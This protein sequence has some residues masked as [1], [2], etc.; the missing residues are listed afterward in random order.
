MVVEV[1]ALMRGIRAFLLLL[2]AQASDAETYT[3]IKTWAWSGVV[4]SLWAGLVEVLWA[5]G[6]VALFD[7]AEDFALDEMC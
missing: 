5:G 4:G 2:L 3:V 7:V 6:G 1:D